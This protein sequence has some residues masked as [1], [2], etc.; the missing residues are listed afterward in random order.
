[1]NPPSE[2]TKL[3]SCL[4]SFVEYQGS[5]KLNNKKVIITGGEYASR[6]CLPFVRVFVLMT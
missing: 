3:E 5:G 4:G 1:M 6:Q 2:A